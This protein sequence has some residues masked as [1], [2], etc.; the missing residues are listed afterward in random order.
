MLIGGVAVIAR[1]VPRFTKDVDAT[2]RADGL[3]LDGALRVLARHGLE[4]RVP[5]PREFARRSQMLL[6]RHQPTKVDVDLS[7]AWLPFERDAIDRAESLSLGGIEIPVARP[8][9]LI[10]YKVVA[11]RLLDRDDVEKLLLRYAKRMDLGR[12]RRLVVEFA[13]ILEVPER[14]AEFDRLVKS[15]LA[16]RIGIPRKSKPRRRQAAAARPRRKHP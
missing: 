8:E 3:P 10:V 13:A 16:E 4:P 15:A 11:W 7:L 12:V 1:G 2:V 9:D 6:L 5:G 14:V